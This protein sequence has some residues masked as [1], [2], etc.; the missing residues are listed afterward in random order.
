M[1]HSYLARSHKTA[2]Q[3]KPKYRWYWKSSL[4][5]DGRAHGV[6]A[7]TKGEARAKI[8]VV[9]GCS[10]N[11]RLPPDITIGQERERIHA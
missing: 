10:P 6:D 7:N 3:K 4:D 2:K 8:K 5:Q 9:I 1:S 11:K